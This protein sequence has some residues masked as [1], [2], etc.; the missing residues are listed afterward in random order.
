MGLGMKPYD[1]ITNWRFPTLTPDFQYIIHAFLDNSMPDPDAYVSKKDRKKKASITSSRPIIHYRVE[2]TFAKLFKHKGSLESVAGKLAAELNVVSKKVAAYR[3]YSY[4]QKL[5]LGVLAIAVAIGTLAIAFF[6]S[7][8][9]A[10]GLVLAEVAVAL[11]LRDC[12]R[13][14]QHCKALRGNAEQLLKA[15]TDTKQ[16][17]QNGESDRFH[18]VYYTK[19]SSDWVYQR[20]VKPLDE[21]TS[22]LKRGLSRSGYSEGD[23]KVW[24]R[25][26]RQVG[27][28]QAAVTMPFWK[29][30]THGSS[31]WF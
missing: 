2:D 20:L 9:A 7:L 14:E 8:K 31:R 1:R 23:L 10:T 13:V 28:L 27:R 4:E 30:I 26:G 29:R 5:G 3:P 19:Q 21:A 11:H 22:L 17:I 18:N 25:S 12:T 16:C 6:I 24:Q 15:I